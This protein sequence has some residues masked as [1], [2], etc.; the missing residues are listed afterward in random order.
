MKDKH[1]TAEILRWYLYS[2]VDETIGEVPQNRFINV[3]LKED[4]PTK[5]E[6]INNSSKII[7]QGS[8]MTETS[9]QE[10]CKIAAA[11][12]SVEELKNTLLNYA[13]CSLRKTATNLVFGDGNPKANIVLLGESPGAEEDRSGLPFV[14]PGG[15]LLDKML[16]SI[17]LD[18][19][20]VFLS[21]TV[22]WRPPGSRTPTAQETGICIPF[23]ERLLELIDPEILIILGGAAAKSLLAKTAAVSRLRGKWYTY[24]TPMLSRPIQATVVFHPDYLLS[25]PVHKRNTWQDLLMIREKLKSIGLN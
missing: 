13:G 3:N 20:K 23:V 16:A 17:G 18:R 21:N 19:N 6:Q 25:S 1:T 9:L 12:K 15:Q 5:K 2:G 14:G 4:T 24:S 22:F 10:A 7:S 11:A 8:V